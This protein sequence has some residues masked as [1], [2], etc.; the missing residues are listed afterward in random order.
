[1]DHKSGESA[2]WPEIYCTMSIVNLDTLRVE[3]VI[4][5]ARSGQVFENVTLP[6]G[7]CFVPRILQINDRI[8]RCYFASEEP[9]KRQAQ[10][11]YRDFDL[12]VRSFAT[13]IHPCK[14][15]TSSGIFPMQPNYFHE[16]AVRHGFGKPAKDYGFYI[17]DGFKE[18]D[19]SIYVALNNFPGKQNALSLLHKDRVTFEIIGHYNEPQDVQ[20]SESSVQRLPDGTWMAICRNDGGSRNY[21]FTTS[22]D[23]SN[24]TTAREMPF[25]PNGWNSKPT[26]DR[27]GDTYYLGWQESTRVEDVN[28][29]VFN[30]D[31]SRDGKT[32][33]RKY[34]FET[35]KSFQYPS[36][37]AYDGVIWLCVTQGDHSPSRKE[38]IMFGQLETLK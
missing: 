28:R 36:F 1:N 27:F 9:G 22:R 10:T 24:W 23:G 18:F 38:R 5:F 37:E 25:V 31:V 4:S 11:W 26:F 29:S 7:A 14:L 3:E 20:L 30:I 8:L 16:D 35:E 34:R 19:G 6:Q 33:Q 17:F 32:W 21:Y 13:A 2:G 12:S 15:K